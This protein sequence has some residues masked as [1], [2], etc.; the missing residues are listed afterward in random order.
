MVH[1]RMCILHKL[2]SVKLSEFGEWPFD[3]GGYFIIKGKEKVILSLEKKVNNILY[4]N[5]SPDD[6]IIL[7]GNIKSIS[8][9]GFQSSRTNIVNFI[10]NTL[11]ER[12][13]SEI[14]IR[15][16]KTFNVRILGIDIMI[17]ICVLFRALGIISDKRIL[18]L[19]I[20][21]KDNSSL[22]DKLI[23]LI[24]PSI[25]ASNPIFNQKSAY[26]L[27]ALNTKGKETFNVIDILNNNLFPNYGNDNLS[28]AYYLGYI[29]RK[30]L[31]THI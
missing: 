13:G 26:K 4:I 6:S 9:E 22:K 10:N 23:E 18:S 15:K 2:D 3:Q 25:R 19:I 5:K 20:Y 31:L 30:M 12:V 24:R 16:E 7:Q 8:N 17:P 27:L 21:E 28:K 29:I 11:R 14:I 1:S